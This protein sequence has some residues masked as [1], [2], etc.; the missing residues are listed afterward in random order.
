MIGLLITAPLGALGQATLPTSS[1]PPSAQA[2]AGLWD[3]YDAGGSE[4]RLEIRI[5]SATYDGGFTF[6]AVARGMGGR[7]QSALR[8][9]DIYLRNGVYDP[10]RGVIRFQLKRFPPPATS[11]AVS[12]DGDCARVARYVQ[13]EMAFDPAA[14]RSTLPFTVSEMFSCASGGTWGSKSMRLVRA[15]NDA[16]GQNPAHNAN[17]V[18]VIDCG[19]D[20]G[21]LRAPRHV[22]KNRQ[23]LGLSPAVC[24]SPRP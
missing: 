7:E 18:E 12:G 5:T 22:M 23:A 19:L 2:L 17:A 4:G 24:G 21:V 9:G 1:L 11:A 3:L 15:P 10:A 14:G 20:N 16:F 8:L 6:N 13:L